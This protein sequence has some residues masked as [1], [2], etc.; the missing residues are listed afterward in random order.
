MKVFE[1]EHLFFGNKDQFTEEA[2]PDYLLS[3][4]FKWWYEGYILKLQVGQ[5]IESDFHKFTRIA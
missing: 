3:K 5:S 4:T 2:P 1:T